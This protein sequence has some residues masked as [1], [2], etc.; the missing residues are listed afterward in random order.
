[1]ALMLLSLISSIRGEAVPK[2]E[3]IRLA[4]PSQVPAGE[5]FTVNVSIRH[6]FAGWTFAD[7][8]LFEEDFTNI[9]DY[10]HYYLTGDTVRNFTLTGAA[11]QT[12]GDLHLNVTT[13]YWFQDFW[14][15][16]AKATKDC[17]VKVLG[18]IVR[19][20]SRPSNVR[21]GD[22]EWY[23][24]NNTASDALLIWLS[25]GHVFSDHVTV[26]P[27]EM[28]NFGVMHLIGDLSKN[29]SVLALHRGSEEHVVPIVNQPYYALGY[30][31]SSTVLKEIH[32]WSLHQG[33][34]FTYL[35]GYSTGGV[36]AAY[37]VAVRD[38]DTWT[39]PNGAIIIS[40]PLE[41]LSP[42]NLLGSLTHARNVKANLEVL[43][44]GI[45]SDDLWPQGMKFYD[46]APNK[47]NAP[48]YL[49]DW[50]LFPESS[51]DVWVKEEDGAH[52]NSDAYNTMARFIE[53]SKSPFDTVAKWNDGGIEVVDVTANRSTNEQQPKS[54]GMNFTTK[55][56][57]TLKVKVWLYNC[58]TVDNCNRSN[59]PDIR[60]DL[61]SSEG[62]IDSRYTN[63]RGYEEFI[64]IVPIG[65]AGKTVKIFATLGGEFKGK[66]TP[67]VNLYVSQ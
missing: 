48:W 24:W 45:W 44:G 26:N 52:Y 49:K 34:N 66:Y 46:N 8:G 35:V 61:Y 50:R 40:A 22:N 62:Y 32:D 17:F 12:S 59:V 43:Y 1:M 60:V 29:Y 10:I 33:Y 16:D 58:T 6:S 25:G 20:V 30:Y 63:T 7:L 54:A 9:L 4:C 19:P 64:L 51:H 2:A 39:A 47:T 23:Y 65:W 67:T 31:P 53:R 13:R 27:Y 41:G 18:S 14:I 3:I 56:G 11:P 38:P 42:S 5:P 37:E 21:I 15:T 28:E 57:N 36:A 55:P